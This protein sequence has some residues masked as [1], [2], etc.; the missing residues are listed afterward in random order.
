MSLQSLRGVAALPSPLIRSRWHR[1]RLFKRPGIRAARSM[2]PPISEPASTRAFT[3]AAVHKPAQHRP[4]STGRHRGHQHRAFLSVRV[5]AFPL[6]LIP[7]KVV[8]KVLPSFE[9][10]VLDRFS[11]LL[12][13]VDGIASAGLDHNHNES[14]AAKPAGNIR[15]PEAGFYD[16]SNPVKHLISNHVPH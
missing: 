14:L 9:Y 10:C 8:V 2:S 11:D 1:F 12:G 5:H 13:R 7:T 16:L 4:T 15:F 3:W 6:R